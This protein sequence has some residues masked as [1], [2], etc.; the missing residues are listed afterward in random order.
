[1]EG[2]KRNLTHPYEIC[3]AFTAVP[4]RHCYYIYNSLYNP[5]I[6]N[7]LSSPMTPKVRRRTSARTVGIVVRWFEMYS[8]RPV[9]CVCLAY[10]ILPHIIWQG[11]DG[12]NIILLNYNVGMCDVS[13]CSMPRTLNLIIPNIPPPEKG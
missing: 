5:F 2:Y 3:N 11:K 10:L 6:T 1:M 4:H 9:K 7:T 8:Q 12:Y 13:A